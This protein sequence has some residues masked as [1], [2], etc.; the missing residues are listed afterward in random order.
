[1]CKIGNLSTTWGVDYNVHVTA[2]M[3]V[4]LLQNGASWTYA[5]HENRAVS[6]GTPGSFDGEHKAVGHTPCALRVWPQVITGV[7]SVLRQLM[8]RKSAPNGGTPILT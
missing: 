3:L 7:N 8:Q 2:E 1:M 5:P 4:V 6:V